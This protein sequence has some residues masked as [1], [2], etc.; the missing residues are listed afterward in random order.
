MK[1]VN[2]QD[3]ESVTSSQLSTISIQ[4]IIDNLCLHKH[5]NSTKQ[6]Y[7]AI[8][9]IFNKF[10][11]RLDYKPKNWSDRLSL[12]V[13]YL[14]DNKKQSSTVRSY[15]CVIKSVLR[16]HG[17]P[18]KEDQ[19]LIS[20]LM[21]ACRMI[22][23]KVHARLPIKTLNKM[24]GC[25]PFLRKLYRCLFS[26]AYFGLFRIGE[27]TMGEHP[28][29]AKDVQIAFNKRKILFILRSSK[30]HSKNSCPQ[31]IKIVSTKNDNAYPK[32]RRK[33]ADQLPCPYQLLCDYLS[34]RGPYKR[35]D[36]PFFIFRD[37]M[38]ISPV[39]FR[40]CLGQVLKASGFNFQ[41]YSGH[42]FRAGRACDM[43]KLGL[44]IETIKKVGCWR[45]NAVFKYLKSM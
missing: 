14:I 3:V 17:I 44:S 40:H 5:R 24:F 27:L 7:L 41:L 11:V 18:I 31:L 22:N 39:Q 10:F 1:T 33:I 6:N 13:G 9:R 42:S 8:W 23:D 21:K 34:V 43:L 37:K 19:Y 26:T 32:N 2:Q 35:D 4:H 45:S 29:L 25:Q 16:D 38:P 36:E 30:T 15:V 12:F 20:S 28:V